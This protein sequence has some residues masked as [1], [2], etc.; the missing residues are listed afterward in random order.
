MASMIESLMGMLSGNTIE[1]ISS[2]VGLPKDKAQEALPGVLAVLTGALA[3]NTSQKEGAISLSNALS[4]DHDGS[5]LNNLSGYIKNYK[6]GEGEGILKH[7]L[8]SKRD[9]VQQSLGAKSGLDAGTI[10]NLLTMAAPIVLGMLGKTQRQDGLNINSLSNLL[11]MEQNQADNLVPGIKDMLA[12][13]L[14]SGQQNQTASQ[15]SQSAGT[16]RKKSPLITIIIILV[17]IGIA[18]F[19]LNYCGILQF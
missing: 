15:S 14:G 17:V 3:K 1:Q 9:A 6:E 18:L 19:V 2:A 5:I 10:G 12:K 7:V 11:G 13:I 16:A 8:G 4:N